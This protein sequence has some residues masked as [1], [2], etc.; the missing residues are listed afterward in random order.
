[1]L[2]WC[3]CAQHYLVAFADVCGMDLMRSDEIK[4]G[5]QSA[6]F[7]SS[8]YVASLVVNAQ[9]HCAGYMIP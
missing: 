6:C 5:F 8:P 3:S 9:L 4:C 7:L 2:V 1:M